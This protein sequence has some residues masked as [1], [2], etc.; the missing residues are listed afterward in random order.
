MPVTAGSAASV[1]DA[2]S[3]KERRRHYYRQYRERMKQDPQRYQWYREKQRQYDQKYHAKKR[4]RR[5][6]YTLS[7]G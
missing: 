5:Q 3:R 2:Q 7:L 4:Q 1:T 6:W